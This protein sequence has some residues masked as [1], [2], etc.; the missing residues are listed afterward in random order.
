MTRRSP[1]GQRAFFR[2]LGCTRMN[3]ELGDYINGAL[4]LITLWVAWQAKRS[5][6]AAAAELALARRPLVLISE[7]KV[8][9]LT[10]VLFGYP[11]PCLMVF[12]TFEDSVGVPST[13]HSTR[14][15]VGRLGTTGDFTETRSATL[16]YKS[17]RCEIHDGTT[18]DPAA[19]E[20]DSPIA[21][22]S[23][24][25]QFS[26]EGDDRC[27][28][29]ACGAYVMRRENSIAMN[30]LRTSSATIGAKS[31]NAVSTRDGS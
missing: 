13:L 29:W 9:Q 11:G 10:G 4:V 17:Q 12:V 31:A 18:F 20:P 15:R 1:A 30:S 5:A 22:V 16:V 6:D 23:V 26:A 3:I 27:Q 25:Y 2:D 14:I 21:E 19:V 8:E 7:W 24:T 28:E